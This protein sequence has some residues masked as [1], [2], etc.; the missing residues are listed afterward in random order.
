MFSLIFH[1]GRNVVN[2]NAKC[3]ERLTYLIFI[4]RSVCF[5]IACLSMRLSMC[6]IVCMAACPSVCNMQCRVR[7][8]YFSLHQSVYIYF[9]SGQNGG[10]AQSRAEMEHREEKSIAARL[11]VVNWWEAAT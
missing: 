4:D 11:D 3:R 2:L 9:Q 5:E 6:L 7:L 8:S 10:N 1:C